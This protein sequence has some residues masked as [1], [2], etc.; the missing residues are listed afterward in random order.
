MNNYS[1]INDIKNAI[2]RGDETYEGVNLPTKQTAGRS[3][4]VDSHAYQLATNFYNLNF[5]N[6]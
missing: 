1:K 5:K 3:K 6:Q 2:L 4:Q